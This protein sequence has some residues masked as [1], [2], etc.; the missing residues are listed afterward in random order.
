MTLATTLAALAAILS[1]V[2]APADVTVYPVDSHGVTVVA[3]RLSGTGELLEDES[4]WSGAYGGE[5]INFGAG[6]ACYTDHTATDGA[7]WHIVQTCERP[8]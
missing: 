8:A 5:L 4:P 2:H 1:P 6:I 7:A 3:P